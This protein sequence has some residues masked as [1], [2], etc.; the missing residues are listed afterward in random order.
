[1]NIAEHVHEMNYNHLPEDVRSQAR[2]CLLDTLGTAIGGRSTELSRI[3][4]D[5]AVSVYGGQG[6]HLWLD[7]REVS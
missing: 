5:F 4:Y 3:I 1:M 7:G 6:A 2:R